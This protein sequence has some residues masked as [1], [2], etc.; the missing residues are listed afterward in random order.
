M[1][2]VGLGGKAQK[3]RAD[4]IGPPGTFYHIVVI[5]VCTFG[6]VFLM[7]LNFLVTHTCRFFLRAADAQPPAAVRVSARQRLRAEGVAASAAAA[8]HVPGDDDP[9][10]G[11]PAPAPDDDGDSDFSQD[12]PPARGKGKDKAKGRKRPAPGAG[13][14]RVREPSTRCVPIVKIA[15]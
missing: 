15:S 4:A 1:G 5:V 13:L 9:D 14:K 2:A 6:R 10:F 8:A 7:I 3:R 12:E 11:P